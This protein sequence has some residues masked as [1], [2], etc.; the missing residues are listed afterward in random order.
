MQSRSAKVLLREL[1]ATFPCPPSDGDHLL[2]E[3]GHCIENMDRGRRA[4]HEKGLKV[5]PIPP[6]P[7]QEDKPKKKKKKKIY[8][9][10]ECERNMKNHAPG[11]KGLLWKGR[12]HESFDKLW[13]EEHVSRD[14]AYQWM[15][16]EFGLRRHEAHIKFLTTDQCKKLV[17][18]SDSRLKRLGSKGTP[19]SEK[20]IRALEVPFNALCASIRFIGRLLGEKQ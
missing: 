3:V 18:A 15:A 8:I 2:V 7:S 5:K 13:R 9:C 11:C 12:A 14:E 1:Y 4:S 16:H 10:D 19:T 20:I 17:R 6:P